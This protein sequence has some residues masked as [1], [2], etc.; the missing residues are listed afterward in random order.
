MFKNFSKIH[1]E[2]CIYYTRT[3]FRHKM[4]C[5]SA[6]ANYVLSLTTEANYVQRLQHCIFNNFTNK[7]NTVM[8]RF[9]I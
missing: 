3:Q 7:K 6:E 4:E 2:I 5:L 9:I 1:V 8:N